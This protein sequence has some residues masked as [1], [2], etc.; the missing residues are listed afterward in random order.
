VPSRDGLTVSRIAVATT[1]DLQITSQ[2][3][4]KSLSRLFQG[5]VNDIADILAASGG[6]FRHN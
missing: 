6:L 5:C 4:E 2:A 3:G 1:L